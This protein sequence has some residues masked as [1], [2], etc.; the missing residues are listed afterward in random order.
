MLKSLSVQFWIGFLS[1]LVHEGDARLFGV[2]CRRYH[3]IVR[4]R[5]LDEGRNSL[6]D[7]NLIDSLIVDKALGML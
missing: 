2:D 1:Q 3:Q 6:L 7:V 5:V 4:Q